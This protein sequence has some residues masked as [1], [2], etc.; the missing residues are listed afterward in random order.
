MDNGDMNGNGRDKLVGNL[1][2]VMQ[3]AEALLRGTGQQMGSGYDA[4]R[5]QLETAWDSARGNFG[6]I[7]EQVMAGSQ[8]AIDAADRYVQSNPWQA[9]GIGAAAG[10]LIGLLIGR[11]K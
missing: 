1:K 11:A 7:E 8:E 10:L 4:A 5:V 9:V 2:S 6:A 3:D